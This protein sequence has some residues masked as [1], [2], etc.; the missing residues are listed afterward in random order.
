MKRAYP[1]FKLDKDAFKLTLL[2]NEKFKTLKYLSMRTGKRMKS[3]WLYKTLR[4]KKINELNWQKL[5]K[6]EI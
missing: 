4:M 6:L 2:N 3:S 1:E 5:V